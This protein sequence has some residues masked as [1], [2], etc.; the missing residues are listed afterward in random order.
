MGGVEA[1][2]LVCYVGP[3]PFKLSD[4]LQSLTFCLFLGQ[5]RGQELYKEAL[6]RAQEEVPVVT[7]AA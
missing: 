2:T 4:I 1:R 3:E 6:K 7:P 5:R